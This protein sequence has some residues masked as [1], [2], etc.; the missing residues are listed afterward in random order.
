MHFCRK[1]FCCN[2]FEA[3]PYIYWTM[4][5]I[6]LLPPPGKILEHLIHELLIKRLE[7]NNMI[8]DAKNVFWPKRLTIKTVF[9]YTSNL[10][11]FLYYNYDTVAV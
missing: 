1:K 3:I 6:S 8:D 10:Y 9:Q 7:Q 5:P 2:L 11:Q 4:S